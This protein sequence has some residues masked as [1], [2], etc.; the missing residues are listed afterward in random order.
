[1]ATLDQRR[2]LLKWMILSRASM[3][4]FNPLDGFNGSPSLS[5][6]STEWPVNLPMANLMLLAAAGRISTIR[7]LL[8]WRPTNFTKSQTSLL[9]QDSRRIIVQPLNPLFPALARE[10]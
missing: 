3:P 1:M 5:P 8:R 7:A 2:L 6:L 10:L 4:R 9:P